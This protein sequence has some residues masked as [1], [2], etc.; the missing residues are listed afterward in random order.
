MTNDDPFGDLDE[1]A[2]SD[3]PADV[4]SP[5]NEDVSDE[6]PT[7]EGLDAEPEPEP[8][9]PRTEAAFDFDVTIQR[10]L[11]AREE[12]WDAFEDVCDFEV[13]RVLRKD[14]VKNISGRELHDACLQLAANNPGELAAEIRRARGLDDS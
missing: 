3:D 6:T 4:E 10:P 8:A 13:R 12:S 11:Y 5:E 9:D 2:G 1:M 7:A 14:G